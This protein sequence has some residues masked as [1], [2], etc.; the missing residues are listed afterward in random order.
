MKCPACGF[1]TTKSY[2]YSMEIRTLAESHTKR[3]QKVLRDTYK[4]IIR[5]VPSEKGSEK[6]FYFFMKIKDVPDNIIIKYC[7][8]YLERKYN[9]EMKGF[10]YL[11][12]MMKTEEK[13]LSRRKWNEKKRFGS[14]PKVIKP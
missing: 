7:L 5:D 11:A 1:V 13:N 2:N 8:V 6:L 10:N 14:A 3:A 4:I 12:S 9:L